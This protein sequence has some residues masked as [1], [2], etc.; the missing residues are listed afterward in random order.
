MP[1]LTNQEKTNYDTSY[2]HSQGQHAPIDAEVN[3][4][5]TDITGITNAE[6]VTNVVSLLQADFDAIG[7]PDA[8]TLY[9]I[10]D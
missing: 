10:T 9:V 2:T 5:N 1:I 7:T 8:N 3:T 6:L 4:I